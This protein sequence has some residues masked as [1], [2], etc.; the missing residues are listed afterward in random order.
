MSKTTEGEPGVTGAVASGSTGWASRSP[1]RSAAAAA[2]RNALPSCAA[3]FSGSMNR[4]LT[5]ISAIAAAADTAPPVTRP[6]A[7]YTSTRNTACTNSANRI[8][9]GT[10]AAII[11]RP[12]ERCPLS[13]ASKARLLAPTAPKARSTGCA[14]ANSTTRE[15]ASAAASCMRRSAPV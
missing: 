1:I 9:P 7:T 11:F 4:E 15:S 12:A 5:A 10:L 14:C 6:T 3:W 8:S 13:A 2:E